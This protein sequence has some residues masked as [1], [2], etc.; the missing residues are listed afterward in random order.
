MTFLRETGEH[1]RGENVQFFEAWSLSSPP[2]P[3]WQVNMADSCSIKSSF[4]RIKSFKVDDFSKDGEFSKWLLSPLDQNCFQE[5]LFKDLRIANAVVTVGS[6]RQPVRATGEIFRRW[7]QLWVRS[8]RE[9]HRYQD[10]FI[11]RSVLLDYF[12]GELDV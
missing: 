3:Y 2:L 7:W 10:G 9:K 8:A 4:I 5:L 1:F 11:F 6:D 12:S